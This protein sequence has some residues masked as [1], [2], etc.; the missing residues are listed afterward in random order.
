M[1]DDDI[2]CPKCGS[3]NLTIGNIGF[4]AGKAAIGG[5]LFGPVGLLA[6]GLGNNQV[7]IVCLDCG[8]AFTP[9]EWE[10]HKRQEE[11]KEQKRIEFQKEKKKRGRAVI[12][13]RSIP[14]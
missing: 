4:G 6:G 12:S 11:K 7:K 10:A 1:E 9:E 5:L 8:H 3:E 13:E 2:K 14:A